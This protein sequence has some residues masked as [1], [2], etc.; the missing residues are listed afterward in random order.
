MSDGSRLLEPLQE[1][2]F[3]ELQKFIAEQGVVFSTE[4]PCV[5][6][7][8]GFSLMNRESKMDDEGV[9]RLLAVRICRELRVLT[10]Q[11]DTSITPYGA[12]AETKEQKWSNL[13][14]SLDGIAKKGQVP[15]YWNFRIESVEE[16]EVDGNW[17]YLAKSWFGLSY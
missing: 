14:F 9:L 13:L 1:F 15:K 7:H 17:R 5:E 11:G 12:G 6:L 3:G 16:T 2:C 4:V 8:T 10:I